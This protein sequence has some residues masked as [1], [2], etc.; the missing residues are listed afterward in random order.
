MLCLDCRDKAVPCLP[1]DNIF[2]N[3]PSDSYR[4]KQDVVVCRDKALPCLPIDN[5]FRNNPSDSYRV[6]QGVVA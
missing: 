5:I 1:I 4:V 6:K 3:N 2:R